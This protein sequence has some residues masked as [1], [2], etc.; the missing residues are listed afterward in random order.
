LPV[1]NANN[2]RK[3]SYGNTAY[4]AYVGREPEVVSH[5]VVGASTNA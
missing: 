5:R 2:Y 4:V 3:K 1:N